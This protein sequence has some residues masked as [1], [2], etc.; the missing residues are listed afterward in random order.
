[1]TL[2]ALSQLR[3][4]KARNKL[5]DIATDSKRSADV[6]AMAADAAFDLQLD[7]LESEKLLSALPAYMSCLESAERRVAFRLLHR[8]KMLGQ[9]ASVVLPD[10][11]AFLDKH[12]K[13]EYDEDRETWTLITE[14]ESARR[15][16]EKDGWNK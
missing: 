7:E 9:E 5:I 13:P 3:S 11:D 10:L 4:A 8:L 12:K 16:I 1:M 6:R 15:I 14:V 2:L